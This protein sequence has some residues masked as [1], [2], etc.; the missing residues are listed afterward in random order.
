MLQE[1]CLPG[2]QQI[3]KKTHKDSRK[4]N[5]LKIYS[6]TICFYIF[7]ELEHEYTKLKDQVKI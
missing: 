3:K 7:L 6:L 2:I 1:S 5:D 4:W